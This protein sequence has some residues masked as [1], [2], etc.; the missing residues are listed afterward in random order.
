MKLFSNKENLKIVLSDEQKEILFW[1]FHHAKLTALDTWLMLFRERKSE[2]PD[3]CIKLYDE[4]S[5][6]EKQELE[7]IF[8]KYYLLRLKRKVKIRTFSDFL[9]T[10]KNQQ[11]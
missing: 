3:Y 7:F 9:N 8:A 4:L 1:L 10:I 2:Y 6:K 11:F 5:L